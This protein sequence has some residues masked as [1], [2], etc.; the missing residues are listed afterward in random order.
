[1]FQCK[2]ELT[3]NDLNK[4]PLQGAGDSNLMAYPIQEEFCKTREKVLNVFY[5][6]NRLLSLKIDLPRLA[7]AEGG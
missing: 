5:K 4:M 7:T 3:A 1:V 6:T 2:D